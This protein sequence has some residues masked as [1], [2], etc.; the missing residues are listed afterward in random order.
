[1]ESRQ[2]RKSE[3]SNGEPH[4]KNDAEGK[5]IYR[6][7]RILSQDEFKL[8]FKTFDAVDKKR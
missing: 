8:C 2:T 1:M 5:I 6:S 7:Y 4:S 3:S